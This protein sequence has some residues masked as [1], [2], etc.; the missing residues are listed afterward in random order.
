MPGPVHPPGQMPPPLPPL[1]GKFSA[2]WICVSLL[3]PLFFGLV[4]PYG[5]Y[6]MQKM[7]AEQTKLMEQK[8]VEEDRKRIEAGEAESDRDLDVRISLLGAAWSIARPWSAQS[9]IRAGFN[10]QEAANE[11]GS[12]DQDDEAF[13]RAVRESVESDVS[14]LPEANFDI[15][16]FRAM[17]HRLDLPV[18][19]DEMISAAESGVSYWTQS[20]PPDDVLFLYR[21]V[22]S[23]FGPRG[24]RCF[25]AGYIL[26]DVR[27]QL[28]GAFVDARLGYPTENISEDNPKTSDYKRQFQI[29]YDHLRPLYDEFG[30]VYPFPQD[31]SSMTNL[32]AA[33][34][35]HDARQRYYE[36]L[37]QGKSE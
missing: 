14:G 24:S 16:Q 29:M 9:L 21:V 11:T 34:M 20:K 5:I 19:V 28:A 30:L 23:E 33:K 31:P 27:T 15:A 18:N 4:V 10:R 36:F 12:S 8:K 25:L 26:Q 37:E 7:D 3:L 2:K 35:V 32:E 1:K 6:H 13:R 22:D 17:V